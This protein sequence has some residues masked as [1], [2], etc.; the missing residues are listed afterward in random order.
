MFASNSLFSVRKKAKNSLTYTSLSG[1]IKLSK[2][3]KE[4]KMKI[5]EVR[6][7]SG[8]TQEMFAKKY[9]IPKRTLEGWEAGKRKP[10]VYV[11]ELLERVV[12]ED[13]EENENENEKI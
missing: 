2:E 3:N 5:K 11:L 9:N 4:E 7:H 6:E 10:P 8:L 12:R 13:K 1:I